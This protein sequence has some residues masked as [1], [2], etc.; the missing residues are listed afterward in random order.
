[1]QR[2]GIRH[3]N[4]TYSTIIKGIKADYGHNYGIS[5]KADLERAFQLLNHLKSSESMIK[6]DEILYNCLIDL[7]V[8]FKDV[9]RAVAVF[10]EMT[11]S[12]VKPSSVTFGILI[13]CY[14]FANQLDNAFNVFMRMKDQ[15]LLPNSV[16]YG[17]LIDACVKNGSVDKALDVYE[18]MKRDNI[19]M[20]TVNLSFFINIQIIYTTLI[21]GF[22]KS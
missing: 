16:T 20:N 13:K 3:D 15:N 11:L 22:A 8:R 9:N 4:F 12:G 14:G 2:E 7:C 5:N 1:M 10:N 21:K 18:S 17:C 6:P 19:P